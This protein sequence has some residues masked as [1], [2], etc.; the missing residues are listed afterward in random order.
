MA[1]HAAPVRHI[2]DRQKMVKC[3]GLKQ[4]GDADKGRQLRL[5]ER[6]RVAWNNS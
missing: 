6:R 2:G 5:G 1:R 4:E 3:S